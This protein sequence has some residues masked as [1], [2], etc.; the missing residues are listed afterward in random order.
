[1]LETR[2]PDGT[3]MVVPEDYAELAIICR[4]TDIE[5]GG[6]K[7][8]GIA[9]ARTLHQGLGVKT[10]FKDWLRRKIDDNPEF[11]D[12]TH[13]EIS[14]RSNLSNQKMKQNGGDRRSIL[15]RLTLDAAKRVA[16]AEHN[17]KGALVR[18]YFIWTEAQ[19][20]AVRQAPVPVQPPETEEL[21]MA[22]A[23]LLASNRLKAVEAK[24][25]ESETR[26]EAIE[27][28]AAAFKSLTQSDGSKTLT[29]ASK[30]LGKQRWLLIEFLINH[31]WLYRQ[32]GA[33]LA[34]DDKRRIGYLIHRYTE[35][36]HKDGS[37]F[38]KETARLT[39]KG[40]A[41]LTLMLNNPSASGGAP[42]QP[43]L[44]GLH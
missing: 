4:A 2:G 26:R 8:V 16:M 1:M 10:A 11:I 17:E 33:L 9:D 38:D 37:K 18:G 24:L 29:E 42:S 27:P 21:L 19:L 14:D 25:V 28:A 31:R 12:G 40:I 44:G 23:F 39:D 15:C 43:E 13:Y 30:I 22:R 36:K 32:G 5:I 41:T 3:W 7:V 34:Y 35:L 20:L 6:R